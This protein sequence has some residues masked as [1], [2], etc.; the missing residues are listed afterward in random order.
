[1]VFADMSSARLSDGRPQFLG[2]TGAALY[3]NWKMTTDPDAAWSGWQRFPTPFGGVQTVAAA[4]LTDGR[5]QLFACSGQLWS[6][7]KV[8]PNNPD[9][10]WAD[11]TPFQNIA[12]TLAVGA[13]GLSD[14]RPQIFVSD[15]QGRLWSSWKVDTDPDGAWEPLTEFVPSPGEV[16]KLV[17]VRLTDGRPQLLV[18]DSLLSTWKEGPGADSAWVLPW[19]QFTAPPGGATRSIAGTARS[20]GLPQFVAV[21]SET[22]QVWR[23]HKTD[24][25]PNVAWS[26][27]IPFPDVAGAFNVAAASLTDGR[28]QVLIDTPAGLF[29][30]WQQDVSEP[31]KWVDPVP[32]DALP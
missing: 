21:D 27:W 29:T 11:W 10:A 2:G 14:G 23:I 32:F 15:L 4:T 5:P 26:E 20:D 25:D 7:W 17:S 8:D 19:Q 13:A 28:P 1:M 12:G 16:L 18:R 9:S 31:D 30:T 22:G 6:T 3:S 24:A